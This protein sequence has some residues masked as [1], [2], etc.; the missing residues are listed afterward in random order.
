M[1][2]LRCERAGGEKAPQVGNVNAYAKVLWQDE[3]T[4]RWTVYLKFRG[5]GRKG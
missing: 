2:D 4:K 1:V 5:R 3:V